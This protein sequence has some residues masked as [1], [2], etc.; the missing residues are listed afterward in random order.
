MAM[1]LPVDQLVIMLA[2]TISLWF[3]DASPISNGSAGDFPKISGAKKDKKLLW[4]SRLVQLGI[5]AICCAISDLHSFIGALALAGSI[6]LLVEG[7]GDS[8]YAAKKFAAYHFLALLLCAYA[9][10]LPKRVGATVLRILAFGILTAAYPLSGWVDS[11]F[12]RAPASLI[13]IWLI[14]LRPIGVKFLLATVPMELV[15]GSRST[16]SMVLVMIFGSLWFVP[17]LFFA[18]TELRKLL[19]YVTCWQSGYLWLFATRF[20]AVKSNEITLFAIVQGI[21]IALIVQVTTGLYARSKS[22]SITN[23]SELFKVNY[24]A[25]IFLVSSLVFLLLM[26]VIFLLKKDAQQISLFPVCQVCGS[27]VLPVLFGRKIYALL[28]RAGGKAPI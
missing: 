9:N 3:V 1:Q 26:P 20:T 14:L 19:A 23:L 12:S 22:D 17:I 10:I 27:M 16:L 25:A 7:Y 13:S 18:K 11:F 2:S 8:R 4:T 28:K 21:F 6:L 15:N 24:F 5:F